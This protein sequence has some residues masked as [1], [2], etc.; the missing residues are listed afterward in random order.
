M[1]LDFCIQQK[2]SAHRG[3]F[4]FNKDSWVSLVTQLVKNPTAMQET[5][6]Q[7]GRCPREG[8]GYPLQYSDLENSMD[9][10]ACQATVHEVAK[11]QP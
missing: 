9:R 3:A 1:E 7:L 11:S 8:N 4:P 10:E 5:L 6:V 2:R